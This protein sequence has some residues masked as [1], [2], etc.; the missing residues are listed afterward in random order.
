MSSYILHFNDENEINK[1]RNKYSHLRMTEDFNSLT[2][3]NT[4]KTELQKIINETNKDGE[5]I[6]MCIRKPIGEC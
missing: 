6:N 4:S 5:I 3:Y 2:I 1:F